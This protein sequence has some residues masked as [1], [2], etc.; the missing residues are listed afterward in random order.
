MNSQPA[1]TAHLPHY[2][3]VSDCGITPNTSC[4]VPTGHLFF[5]NPFLCPRA[6]TVLV[7]YD[8]PLLHTLTHLL[9]ATHLLY[10]HFHISYQ[11]RTSKGHNPLRHTAK[12]AQS[13]QKAD[14]TQRKAPLSTAS[15][16]I[17]YKHNISTVLSVTQKHVLNR[18]NLRYYLFLTA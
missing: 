1:S 16:I 3:S 4:P 12:T 18:G 7:L 6:F 17:C 2:H 10:I 8:T 13:P 11:R 14:T 9:S 5:R 15:H